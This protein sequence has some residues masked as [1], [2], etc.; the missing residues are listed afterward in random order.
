MTYKDFSG[1]ADKYSVID[2]TEDDASEF[3]DLLATASTDRPRAITVFM[4][5]E[6]DQEGSTVVGKSAGP[7][8]IPTVSG[9]SSL[10][11]RAAAW[12]TVTVAAFRTCA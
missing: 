1:D 5:E 9:T 12:A 6:I 3:N 2:I 8:G 10:K 7:P 11:R 4:V